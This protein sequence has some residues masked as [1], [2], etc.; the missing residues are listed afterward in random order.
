[1]P[2]VDIH[3]GGRVFQVA[4]QE[5]EEQFLQSAASLLDVEAQALAEAMGRVPEER[6]LLMAGLMLADKTAGLEE[7]LRALEHRMAE[8]AR[9][10]PPVADVAPEKVEV[11]IEVPVVPDEVVQTLAALTERAEKLAGELE[12]KSA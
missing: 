9:A 6:M 5:G 2:E 1:M 7:E 3:I 11:R 4:C 8:Q 12:R 10:V